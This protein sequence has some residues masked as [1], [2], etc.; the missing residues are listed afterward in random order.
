M[1]GV[2]RRWKREK[3]FLQTL[4]LFV[5]RYCLPA[6]LRYGERLMSTINELS[7]R[8]QRIQEKLAELRGYL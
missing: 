1:L 6:R 4:E 2:F 5:R 3:K 8:V 7:P